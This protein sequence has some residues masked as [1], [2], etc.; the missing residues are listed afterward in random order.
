MHGVRGLGID[1]RSIR[2]KAKILI[3]EVHGIALV[4]EASEDELG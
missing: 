3:M 4:A 1:C 2:Q